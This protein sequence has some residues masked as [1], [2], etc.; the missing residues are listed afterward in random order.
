MHKLF[1]SLSASVSLL[2]FF[3]TQSAAEPND[4][5]VGCAEVPAY[6]AKVSELRGLAIKSPINCLELSRDQYTALKQKSGL[7]YE[8]PDRLDAEEII[9]KQI[10]LIPGDYAYSKCMAEPNTNSLV[11]TYDAK[12]NALLLPIGETID[13]STLAHE[14]VHA[15]LDQ[16]FQLE[17]LREKADQSTDSALAFAAL[18]EGDARLIAEKFPSLQT[19]AEKE[20]PL[21]SAARCTLPVELESQFAFPSGFGFIYASRLTADHGVS[22][23]NQDYT[24]PPLCTSAI[25]HSKERFRN[26]PKWRVLSISSDE[27]AWI[28]D[29]IG[30]ATHKR[31]TE[32]LGEYTLGLTLTP[33]LGREK[34]MLAAKGWAGDKIALWQGKSRNATS[35]VSVWQN[36]NE[37]LQYAQYF[38]SSMAQRFGV[39]IDPLAR[40]WQFSTP[41]GLVRMIRKEARIVIVFAIS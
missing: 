4:Q 1:V 20:D 13:R 5:L 18:I 9:Y 32:S 28:D 15:L 19:E 12:L 22:A 30:E 26:C 2:L 40:S 29:Y 6:L 16:N 35:W 24:N 21:I 27:R 31:Y 23:L 25:L 3:C 38:S 33:Q 37:A 34:A 8:N 7:A 17:T 11:A 41:K 10:G 36:S 14:L 39:P